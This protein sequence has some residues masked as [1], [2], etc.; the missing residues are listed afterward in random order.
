[1][2]EIS[3]WKNLFEA[4]FAQL[5]EAIRAEKECSCRCSCQ[6]DDEQ[7]GDDD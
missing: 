2:P 5:T 7:D 6:D 3:E 4:L 1:M